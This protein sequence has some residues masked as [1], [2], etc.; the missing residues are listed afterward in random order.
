M[1]SSVWSRGSQTTF[2]WE[3]SHC[4]VKYSSMSY[5]ESGKI[6]HKFLDI[7]GIFVFAQRTGAF[8]TARSMYCDATKKNTLNQ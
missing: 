5:P 3:C 1:R 8:L 6:I 2:L 4:K 7:A